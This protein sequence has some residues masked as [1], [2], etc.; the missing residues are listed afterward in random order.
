[1]HDMLPKILTV[2]AIVAMY[3]LVIAFPE[4][5]DKYLWTFFGCFW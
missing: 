2:L 3:A 1:M 4:W 5:V